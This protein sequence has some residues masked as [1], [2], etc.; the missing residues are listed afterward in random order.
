MQERLESLKQQLQQHRRRR[1]YEAY[2]WEQ[3]HY[4]YYMCLLVTEFIISALLSIDIASVS[5]NGVDLSSIP[6]VGR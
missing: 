1:M 2:L 6:S 5:A 4:R 3:R